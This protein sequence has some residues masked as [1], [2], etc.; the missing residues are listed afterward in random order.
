MIT[1]RTIHFGQKMN[2]D[3]KFNLKNRIAKFHLLDEE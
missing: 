3:A 2:K 1:G